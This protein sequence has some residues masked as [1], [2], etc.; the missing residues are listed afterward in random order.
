MLKLQIPTT[1]TRGKLFSGL[2]VQ[3]AVA[4]ALVCVLL[5]GPLF[6]AAPTDD[7]PL[8]GAKPRSAVSGG[9]MSDY[10]IG[11][12]DILTVSI[13]EAPEFSGK[14]RVSSSGFV[15]FR[16]LPSRFRLRANRLRNSPLKFEKP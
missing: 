16:E 6:A 5:A 11:A 3:C 2:S 9:P 12:D 1:S 14:F 4:S 13:P 10:T 8:G 7:P 15:K